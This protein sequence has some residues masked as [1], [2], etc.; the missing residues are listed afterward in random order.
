MNNEG[1]PDNWVKTVLMV[2]P[3]TKEIH[4]IGG[5][6][7]KG[8]YGDGKYIGFE[9]I[10]EWVHGKPEETKNMKRCEDMKSIKPDI[11]DDI[12]IVYED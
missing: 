7:E 4:A 6:R 3:E 11:D 8:A 12:P 9:L 5:D 2:N 10:R 1:Y